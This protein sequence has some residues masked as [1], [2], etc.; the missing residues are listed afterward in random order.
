MKPV[1][2]KFNFSFDS[3]KT[4]AM[5]FPK[6]SEETETES[7]ESDKTG[8]ILSATNSPTALKMVNLT[9]P[10]IPDSPPFIEKS[11]EDRETAM[12][13]WSGFFKKTLR[14]RQ[15][16][17]GLVYPHLDLSVLQNGGLEGSVADV[18]IENCIGVSSL[19]IGVAPNFIVNDKLF[20]VPMA[21]EE[22]SV[23]AAASGA[24]KLIAG[25][26]GFKAISTGNVMTAQLQLCDWVS[27]QDM[28]HAVD[29]IAQDK[30][31]L[32]E[33]ANSYCESMKRRGGGVVDIYA[34]IVEPRR[35]RSYQS[36]GFVIVHIDVCSFF[37]LNVTFRLMFVKQWVLMLLTLLLK[38]WLPPSNI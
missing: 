15:D 17:I 6:E 30:T 34:R 29:L 10:P 9:V 38:D 16:Q 27:R 4:R 20:V 3:I 28:T 26:G 21:V 14:E 13:V 18:M 11:K 24:A 7:G 2:S 36:H 35:Q 25:C 31:R 19:P 12:A 32:I 8:S 23:I 1:N 33:I 37:V 5:T 22:P